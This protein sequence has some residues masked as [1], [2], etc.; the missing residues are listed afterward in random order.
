MPGTWTRAWHQAAGLPG[1][2]PAG[3][4]VSRIASP[5]LVRT[6]TAVWLPLNEAGAGG[7]RTGVMPSLFAVRHRWAWSRNA[8]GAVISWHSTTCGSCARRAATLLCQRTSSPVSDSPPDSRLT[9]A[10][11]STACPGS[12]GGA[13][14]GPPGGSCTCY[15]LRVCGQAVPAGHAGV[16]CPAA[17]GGG[18]GDA[19]L[20]AG[21]PA[22]GLARSR[23]QGGAGYARVPG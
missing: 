5:A 4:P 10:I 14:P 15:L 13:V 12:A 7:P 6:R 9:E 3:G 17:G 22:P 2:G 18:A 1:C 11:R 8:D 19:D 20:P 21:E 16:P 23:P